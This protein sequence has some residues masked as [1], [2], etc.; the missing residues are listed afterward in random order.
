[1]PP[2][3]GCVVDVHYPGFGTIVVD[4][5]RFDHDVV[6]EAGAVRRR[7]K[8]PSK[9]HRADFGHTPLSPAEDIPW[10]APR[11]VIGTGAN[12][13][14]PIMRGVMDAA[15]EHGVQVTTLPTAEACE[16]LRSIDDPNVNAILHVTC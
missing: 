10:T 12:G 3:Y 6:V 2:A 11:L 14:L 7:E 5:V 4:G 15:D 9:S 16:L 8:G 1:M 13:R